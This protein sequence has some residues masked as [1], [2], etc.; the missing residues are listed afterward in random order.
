MN[1]PRYEKFILLIEGVQKSIKKLKYNEAPSLGIKSVH[2]FWLLHLKESQKGLTAAELASASMV[3][4]SLVS[5]EIEALIKGGYVSLE[6]EGRHYTLTDSG[7]ALADAIKAKMSEVQSSVGDGISPEE[8]A[9]FY[10]VLEKLHGNF[11][12]LTEKKRRKST[13]K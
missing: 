5:R 4:R 10:R 8:L 11:A 12:T 13:D 1:K 6:D 3:D 2:I 9:I 7:A